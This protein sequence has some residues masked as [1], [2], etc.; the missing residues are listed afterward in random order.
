MVRLGGFLDLSTSD[1]PG[2]PCAVVF[3]AG[4]NFRC[5]FCQNSSLIPLD[6]GR[7][8][9]A[10]EVERRL[11]S[12]STLVDALHVTGGECTLQPA[13]LEEVCRIAKRLGMSVG[14]DT[15]ASSPRVL[16]RLV[17]EGL[18]DHVAMDVKAPLDPASYSKATGVDGGWAVRRVEES[19]DLMKRLDVTL[20]V[21]TT[22]V[23]GL[24]DEAEVISIASR[25]PDPDYY[26]LSQFVPSETV[27][28]PSFRRLPATPRSLL[29]KLAEV[30][31]RY[32]VRRVY[33]RTREAGLERVG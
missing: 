31:L 5:P 17:E 9:G 32:G 26:V 2:R 13:G 15:N 33:V 27:L 16:A 10:E 4:C 23:P 3:F 18:V 24:I 6:S 1:W 12:A 14:V 8:V 11:K 25:L 28:D 22:V 19:L 29:L 7:E 20:E 21:R 30:A